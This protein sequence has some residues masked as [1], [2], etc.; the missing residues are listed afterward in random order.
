[1]AVP[2]S[3]L[4]FKVSWL[5][6]THEQ[7]GNYWGNIFGPIRTNDITHLSQ[8]LG[9]PLCYT[10]FTPW[11][12]SHWQWLLSVRAWWWTCPTVCFQRAK[13]LSQEEL[14]MFKSTNALCYGVKCRNMKMYW[15]YCAATCDP[16]TFPLG[17]DALSEILNSKTFPLGGKVG[18]LHS[19]LPSRLVNAVCRSPT[20]TLV[21]TIV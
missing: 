21:K 13:I 18:V 1:M 10:L 2:F 6:V 7:T 4:W 3:A 19:V 15:Y 8:L 20:V 11:H 14:A 9:Q 16:S 5:R 17:M 12:L